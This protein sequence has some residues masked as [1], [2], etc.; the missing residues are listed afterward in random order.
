MRFTRIFIFIL[1]L[2]A[3]IIGQTNK[4][5]ITGTVTDAKGAPIPGADC[6]GY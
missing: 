5:G 4:G 3:T 6:D 1:L 2:T